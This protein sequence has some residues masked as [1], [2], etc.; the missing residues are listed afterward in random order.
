MNLDDTS[1]LPITYELYL[2]HKLPDAWTHSAQGECAQRDRIGKLTRVKSLL[3]QAGRSSST[4]LF[5]WRTTV[6]A[7]LPKTQRFTPDRP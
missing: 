7:T 3:D 2:S 1:F 4:G 6:S 5:E